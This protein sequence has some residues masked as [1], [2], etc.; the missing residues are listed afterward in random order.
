MKEFNVCYIVGGEDEYK[1]D[2]IEMLNK[3]LK[4]LLMFY[5]VDNL[6]IIVNKNNIDT[7]HLDI[8]IN[9]NN[10][11]QYYIKYTDIDITNNLKY[12]I[13]NCNA[14]RI[15]RTAL[16]KFYIPDIVDCD[17]IFYFDCDVL[18]NNNLKDTLVENISDSCLFKMWDTEFGPN[19]GIFYL[20]C[21][22]YKSLNVLKDVEKYYDDN[23]L[24]CGYVD[25]SCFAHLLDIYKD[26]I[27]LANNEGDNINVCY[28]DV[29]VDILATGIYHIWSLDKESFNKLFEKIINDGYTIKL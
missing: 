11:K 21:K 7:L 10:C 3:S 12:P 4:T 19:S 27:V 8:D 22:L 1:K 5:E 24:T 9:F 6:Y 28:I 23:Y 20:N 17:D 29:N 14:G 15:N 26:R 2:Y 13:N 25:Q 16:L 18:F